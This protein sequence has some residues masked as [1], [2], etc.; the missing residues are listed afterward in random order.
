MIRVLRFGVKAGFA[1]PLGF[2][3]AVMMSLLGSSIHSQEGPSRGLSSTQKT[4]LDTA[5]EL[6]KAAK[7][8]ELK[9]DLHSA[10]AYCRRAMDTLRRAGFTPQGESFHLG[11]ILYD[12]GRKTEGY[13]LMKSAFSH[14]VAHVGMDTRLGLAAIEQK[15]PSVAKAIVDFYRRDDFGTGAIAVSTHVDW[16]KGDDDK[17][18]KAMLLFLRASWIYTQ[19]REN[20]KAIGLLTEANKLRPNNA[21]ILYLHARCLVELKKYKESVPFFKFVMENATGKFGSYAKRRYQ[22]YSSLD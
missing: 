10:E 3:L 22:I 6:M 11:S 7:D 8:A 20:D 19:T 14:P 1:C 21:A 9:G 15:E 17:T 2:L 13:A 18:L 12:S 4:S 16:P 5:E